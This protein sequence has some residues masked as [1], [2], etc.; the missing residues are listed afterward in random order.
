MTITDYRED[1]VETT[2]FQMM[3]RPKWIGA[4]V[5]ALL[6]AAIFAGLGQW[7]LGRAIASGK[8]VD[9]PTETVLPLTHV[10][11]PGGPIRDAAV[12]QKVTFTGS[13]NPGD[14]Q[15]LHGRLNYGRAGYWVVAHV[16][17][18]QDDKAG[19]P[20][21]IAVA[22]GWASDLSTAEAAIARLK[23]KP[24]V[25]TTITGRILPTE[26]PSLPSTT[27]NP[28][29][30]QDM[31][32]AALY[33]L[34]TGVEDTDVYSA[35]IVEKTPPVGLDAIY[36]PPPI[37]DATLDWLNVFYAAEW[38]IFAGFAIFFWFRLVKDAKEKED[39]E[40][41]ESLGLDTAKVTVN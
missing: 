26:A 15:L 11:K 9:V 41:E 36:A 33:N 14:Y 34:W 28:N 4:L 29:V 13:F 24:A 30:M 16:T 3:R 38:A 32:V 8:V 39:Q 27:G 2:M 35:Y 5:L 6:L 21:A 18:S 23:T 40:R 1:D 31:S 12:G 22:R 19:A 37:E 20:V 25:E 7:Q 10:A 17:L